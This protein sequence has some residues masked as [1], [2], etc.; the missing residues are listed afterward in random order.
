MT[1]YNVTA[2]ERLVFASEIGAIGE[3]RCPRQHPLFAEYGPIG[4]SVFVF[5]RT[6][7][8]IVRDDGETI[9]GNPNVVIFYNPGDSCRRIAVG[10]QDDNC[11]WFAIAPALLRE[12]L[13]REFPFRRSHALAS[14]A[15][16]FLQRNLVNR[17]GCSSVLAVEEELLQI[18]A[19]VFRNAFRRDDACRA[20]NAPEVV[21][22]AKEIVASDLR[23]TLSLATIAR[24]AGCSVFYL[25]RRFHSSTGMRLYEFRNGIRMRRS[26]DLLS[27][28]DADVFAVALELGYSTH[29]HFTA[30]FRKTF[31]LTPSRYRDSLPL[32]TPGSR[33]HLA[34]K[35]QAAVR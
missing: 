20:K 7:V 19:R 26:L 1:T 15:D 5:P 11:E 28:P 17:L 14:A 12:M 25:S 13:P 9:V 4:S 21:E 3:F 16:Y 30:H 33:S 8:K 10:N 22:R 29:S 27:H 34:K 2:V 18:A 24:L 23:S 6:S 32:R 31:G 35:I